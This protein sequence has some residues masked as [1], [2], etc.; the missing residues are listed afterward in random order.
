MTHSG[1]HLG[2]LPMYVGLQLQDGYPPTSLHSL[3]GPQGDGTQGFT[4]AGG[5][6]GCGGGAR[7]PQ[8]LDLNQIC[9]K[10]N[11]I[12]R[13][14]GSQRVK[15]FPVCPGLQLQIGLWLIT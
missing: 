13:G 5:V 11:V 14:I 1:L 12:V 7:K 6:G 4:Y 9:N 15:G 10:I 8:T 3:L 2:G